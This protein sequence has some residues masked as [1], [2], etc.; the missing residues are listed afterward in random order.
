MFF[1]ISSSTGKQD[2]YCVLGLSIGK[3]A[4]ETATNTM[5][6]ERTPR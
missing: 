3:T 6:S 2:E 5:K 1:H 4:L